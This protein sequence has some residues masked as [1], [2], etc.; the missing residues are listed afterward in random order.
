MLE[1]LDVDQPG[2]CSFTDAETLT[3]LDV[4]LEPL[5]RG[6]WPIDPGSAFADYEPPPFLRPFDLASS[7]ARAGLALHLVG[8]GRGRTAAGTSAYLGR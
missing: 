1:Q 2:H 4:H 7:S 3:A 8:S 6:R 5:D